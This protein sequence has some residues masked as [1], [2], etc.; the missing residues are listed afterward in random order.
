MTPQRASHRAILEPCPQIDEDGLTA[1]ILAR[2][3]GAKERSSFDGYA[4]ADYRGDKHDS[5]G[6][7]VLAVALGAGPVRIV[8]GVSS[9]R[10]L[11]VALLRLLATA[12]AAGLRVL[13]G[14]DHQ[15][16]LPLAFL[17]ELEV[18]GDW[19]AAMNEVFVTGRFAR[20]AQDGHAGAFAAEVN[21]WLGGRG[22]PPY[23]WSATKSGYGIPGR[24]PRSPDHASQ[25]RLTETAMG[26]PFCRVGDS[27]SVGGQSIVGIPKLLR[28]LHECERAGIPVHVWPFDDIDVG[29]LTGHVAIEP[30][31]SLVREAGIVQTDVNDAV[32]ST[33]WAQRLDRE[34][35]LREV[36][37]LDNLSAEE[38]RRVRLEGWMAGASAFE[39]L[40]P[41]R[42]PGSP[43][44]RR[45][46]TRQS[47]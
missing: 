42:S 27:G 43:R 38:Q 6:G 26:F 22:L 18:A 10:T 11:S 23:F 17:D 12:T 24:N 5:S 37:S 7:V 47:G 32:A 45:L 4:F 28:L 34:G 8:R 39:G 19:R 41:S 33:L 46:G 14:Q 36:L 20:R 44:P 29:L 31:P 16:G 2:R 15:Y 25:R 9:R 21:E 30:Y 1:E 13:F 3:R 35:T 40:R